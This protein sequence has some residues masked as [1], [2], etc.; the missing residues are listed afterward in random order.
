M[1]T[2]N[3]RLGLKTVIAISLGSMLGSGIFV[4]PGLVIQMVGDKAWLAYLLAGLCVLPAAVSKSELATAMPNSG[5]TYVYLERTFGPL[6]GTVAGLGLWLSLLLKCAFALAGI[7]AYLSVFASWPL[8]PTAI[9]LLCLLTGL[10]ILGTG[11]VG[12]VIVFIVSL[13]ILTLT[14]LSLGAL[15]TLEPNSSPGPFFAPSGDLVGA[16][17]MVFVSYAGLT[18]VAAIA[19]EVKSPEKNLPRGIFISLFIVICVYCFVTFVM[20]M[21]VPLEQLYGNFKPL[22]TFSRNVSGPFLATAVSIVAFL[23]MTSMANSGLLAASRFPFAMGRDRLLPKVLGQIHPK[24]LTPLW[25][26]L[27]SGLVVG[28][29]LILLDLTKI[30]KLASAFMIMIYM[31]ESLAVFLLREMR[32]QWFKPTYRSQFYPYV[33]ILGV[34][35]SLFL[36][37]GMGL[38]PLVAFASIGL[39]G[40]LLYFLYGRKRTSRRGV[41][42]FRTKRKE[43]LDKTEIPTKEEFDN[44]Q[45]MVALLGKERSPD[46]LIEL[47]CYLS[48]D[49]S[50]EVAHLTEVPEQTDI[51]DLDQERPGSL[52]S[53]NRRA[54]AMAEELR[55]SISFDPI[56]THDLLGALYKISLKSHCQ[57]LLMEWGGRHRGRF[58]IHDPL[59]WLKDHLDCHLLT[60]NSAG[61]RYIKKIMILIRENE[62][63]EASLNVAINLAKVHKAN[64][65]ILQFFEYH[66]EQEHI[67]ETKASLQQKLKKR[68]IDS[69]VHAIKCEKGIKVNKNIVDISSEYDLMIFSAGRYTLWDKVVRGTSDDY[70]MTKASCATLSVQGKKVSS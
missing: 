30:A 62:E 23:T 6:A 49:K 8:L 20:T 24:F 2:L 25:G 10:N 39:P 34:I 60:F 35:S 36:L 28:L 63:N 43:F 7:G 46:Q 69:K 44:A 40:L 5:G 16:T 1:G 11:K 41:I 9:G 3:A 21:T 68:N 14:G 56:I 38:L 33:Q 32:V 45:V 37:T 18:K 70:F 42:G 64:I 59:G 26:I 29:C 47:G 51:H 31:M 66:V 61:V 15:I 54:E 22:Y 19:E 58:T 27:L 12:G 13:S 67:N 52:K 4:L 53:L 57:Y 48:E 17:A 50:L 65:N 55:I